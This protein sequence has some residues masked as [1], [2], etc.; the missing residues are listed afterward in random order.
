MSVVIQHVEGIKWYEYPDNDKVSQPS[1]SL[2]SVNSS[3]AAVE[4]I[5]SK[6]NVD[7][8][9]GDEKL[10]QLQEKAEELLKA[11]IEKFDAG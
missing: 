10:K 1:S 8:T 7:F 6:I 2:N 4:F 5:P 9:V 11:D 3:T